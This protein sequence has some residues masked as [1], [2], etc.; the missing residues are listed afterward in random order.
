VRRLGTLLAV[1]V[2]ATALSGISSA[3]ASPATDGGKTMPAAAPTAAPASVQVVG[4]CSHG[5]RLGTAGAFSGWYAWA[6]CR[7]GT[8]Y[9]RV[10]FGCPHWTGSVDWVWG[11]TRRVGQGESRGQCQAH[12]RPVVTTVQYWG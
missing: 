6:I 4:N 9:Y 12:V 8:G 10:G 11:P 1:A 7:S 5:T 3:T 2:I